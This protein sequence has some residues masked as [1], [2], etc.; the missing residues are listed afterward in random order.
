MEILKVKSTKNVDVSKYSKNTI[1]SIM[2][3]I[4]NNER[5]DGK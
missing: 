5:N 3:K 1:L 2:K 4:Y